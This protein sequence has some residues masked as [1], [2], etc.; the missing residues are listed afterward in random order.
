MNDEKIN[1]NVEAA[2]NAEEFDVLAYVEA[3]EVASDE[4]TVYVSVKGAKDLQKLVLKRQELLAERR[5]QAATGN[6]EPMGLDEA[7]EDTEYDDEIN[8]L[9][10]KLEE[11]ALIFE[12]KTVAPKLTR[13]IEQHY[14]ATE[15]KTWTP[16]EKAKH[17]ENRLMEIL[18]KAIAGARTGSGQRD[19]KPWDKE[20]LAALEET[21]YAEQF[22]KLV[23]GLYEMVFT[24]SVFEEALSADFS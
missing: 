20:R 9:V 18:S 2:L 6:A 19:E 1:A 10:D 4:V 8:A 3:Q 5:A 24:G 11:T 14:V 21:I 22:A 13:A 7:Y 15:V 17:N 16:E 12:L 23:S